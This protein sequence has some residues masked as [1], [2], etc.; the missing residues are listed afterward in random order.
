MRTLQRSHGL[1]KS[2]KIYRVFWWRLQ[3]CCDERGGPLTV[4]TSIPYTLCRGDDVQSFPGKSPIWII[5]TAC[6]PEDSSSLAK[7]LVNGADRLT[8]AREGPQRW[9]WGT[10]DRALLPPR[11]HFAAQVKC[12]HLLPLRSRKSYFG[13]QMSAFGFQEIELLLRNCGLSS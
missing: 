2:I 7:C 12:R 3:G 11:G 1:L 4:R 6:S 9:F 13:K 10:L 5:T 8:T